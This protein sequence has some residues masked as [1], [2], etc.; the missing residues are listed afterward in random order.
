MHFLALIF[1]GLEFP[2]MN[3]SKHYFFDKQKIMHRSARSKGI[4]LFNAQLNQFV[5]KLE[6]NEKPLNQ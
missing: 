3:G 1:K 6:T 5:L 4:S 2:P